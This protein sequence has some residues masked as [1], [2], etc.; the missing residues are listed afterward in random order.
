MTTTVSHLSCN[1]A[2]PGFGQP[3]GSQ[4][5]GRPRRSRPYLS[6]TGFYVELDEERGVLGRT[7]HHF[8][9]IL[10]T[11][12]SEH[13]RFYGRDVRGVPVVH[14]N[15]VPDHVLHVSGRRAY[16][17]VAVKVMHPLFHNGCE[18]VYNSNYLKVS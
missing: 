6:V 3:L 8:L 5:A 14:E 9:V 16:L 11:I 13:P 18:R 4:V 12:F 15:A 7:R 1:L 10:D 17:R 2:R